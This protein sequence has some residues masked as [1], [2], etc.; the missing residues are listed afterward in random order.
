LISLLKIVRI[1]TQN[2]SEQIIPYFRKECN[3]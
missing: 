2:Y 3:L 1:L